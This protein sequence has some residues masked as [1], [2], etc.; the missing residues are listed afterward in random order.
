MV[1][2]FWSLHPFVSSKIS[3]DIPRYLVPVQYAM[4][5]HDMSPSLEAYVRTSPYPNSR[6]TNET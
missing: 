4:I 2:G 3:P 5:H 1:F 6:P